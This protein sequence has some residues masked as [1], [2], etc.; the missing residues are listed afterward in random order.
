MF[1]FVAISEDTTTALFPVELCTAYT[2]YS[3]IRL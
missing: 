1:A 3:V 2:E